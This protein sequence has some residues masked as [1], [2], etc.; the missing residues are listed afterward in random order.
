MSLDD[1]VNDYARPVDNIACARSAK[2]F[3]MVV[4]WRYY[5]PTFLATQ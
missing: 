5:L 4:R 2:I 1:Q 3:A